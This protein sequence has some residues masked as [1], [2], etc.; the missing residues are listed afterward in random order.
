[1]VYITQAIFHSVLAFLTGDSWKKHPLALNLRTSNSLPV[2]SIQRKE[3][4]EIENTLRKS[5]STKITF[6]LAQ[7]NHCQKKPLVTCPACTCLA[8]Q[9][10]FGWISGFSL[11]FYFFGCFLFV[12][13]SFAWVF[14][15]FSWSFFLFGLVLEGVI[16]FVLKEGILVW[17]CLNY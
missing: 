7:W 13:G 8:S 10:C 5:L 1:M 6:M 2:Q 3:R 16:F 15:L 12:L 14:G 4:Q 9:D 17:F 11:G